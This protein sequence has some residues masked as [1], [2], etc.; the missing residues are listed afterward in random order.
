MNPTTQS[1]EEAQREV[2]LND[3]EFQALKAKNAARS[4]EL[5]LKGLEM[6]PYYRQQREAARAE[7]VNSSCEQCHV[8]SRQIDQRSEGEL[9]A[10]SLIV[11]PIS[12]V[13]QTLKTVKEVVY[14]NVFDDLCGD[15]LPTDEREKLEQTKEM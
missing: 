6:A 10:M 14:E 1:D 3:P 5:K 11:N 9:I 15:T 8:S 13:T 4:A 12:D 7:F 2:L